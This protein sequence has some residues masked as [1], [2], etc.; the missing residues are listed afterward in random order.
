[1]K[2][3]FSNNFFTT[4]YKYCYLFIIGCLLSFSLP[5]YNQTWI[6]FFAF[7]LLLF[8]LIK[9]QDSSYKSFFIFGCLF[10]FGYFL[11]S[12]YWIHYSLNFDPDLIILKPLSIIAIPA[13]LSIFYGL[14]FLCV[15]KFVSKKFSFIII[16]SIILAIFD[17][18]RGHVFT[19]F[20]WNLFVYTWSWSLE[21]IQILNLFGTYSL[22][23]ISIFIFSLPVIIYIE[24]NLQKKISVSLFLVLIFSLNFYYGQSFLKKNNLTVIPNLQIVTVQPDRSLENFLLEN[25]EVNYVNQLITI[26]NPQIYKKKQTVFVWPEGVLSNLNNLKIYQNMIKENFLEN[27]VIIF[28]ATNLQN[29]KMFNSLVLVDNNGNIL[30]IYSKLKLVPFG[31]FIPFVDLVEKLN[32]KKITFGYGSFQSGPDRKPISIFNT[33]SFLPLICYEM[34]FTGAVNIDT[35]P[36]NF[37]LNISEDGWFNKSVGVHQHFVH[38]Q[39]RAIE[40][41]KHIIRSTNQG[42]SSSILP[43]GSVNKVTKL[44]GYSKISTEIYLNNEETVFSVYKNKIFYLLILILSVLLVFFKKNE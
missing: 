16:F 37:I 2:N 18:V 17:F 22:N 34:I 36:Y 21:S 38:S 7:P 11:C 4:K 39:F 33:L 10:G 29:N 31:E 44:D 25:N 24:N 35:K 40:E 5:P 14:S 3:Y 13:Y 12:L 1:M 15:K 43:N 20:P 19:G 30:N 32:L 41:G 26:S 28:G 8:F 23:L 9:N 42:F 6:S 27:H